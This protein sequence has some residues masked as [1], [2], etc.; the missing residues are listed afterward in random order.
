MS[1][2]MPK[3]KDTKE[4]NASSL[5]LG[6]KDSKAGP[7][8][9]EV[10]TTEE[11]YINS[12]GLLSD[13]K[14]ALALKKYKQKG[15]KDKQKQASFERLLV[16]CKQ[17]NMAHK[18]LFQKLLSPEPLQW[19]EEMKKMQQLY[20]EYNMMFEEINK[21]VPDIVNT[22]IQKEPPPT[23]FPLMSYLIMPV[24]R[25]PR[26][27][28]LLEQM[29]KHMPEK[30]PKRGQMQQAFQQVKDLVS[31]I[32]NA[33]RYATIINDMQV[34]A[35][36]LK[37]SKNKIGGQILD[38]IVFQ[39]KEQ[40][41]RN[42]SVDVALAVGS[43][44][45]EALRTGTREQFKAE[46][47]KIK[48]PHMKNLKAAAE[49]IAVQERQEQEGDE[50]ERKA[51]AH[52]AQTRESRSSLS[53]SSSPPSSLSPPSPPES[54]TESP[55]E[56]EFSPDSP[57]S[58][59][60]VTQPSSHD[61]PLPPL[62]VTPQRK[63]RGSSL[64]PLPS[65]P[66][67][68]KMDPSLLGPLPE[69]PKHARKRVSTFGIDF[70]PLPPLP[71]ERQSRDKKEF[72]A[73]LKSEP[74]N[75]EATAVKLLHLSEETVELEN[76]LLAI[77]RLYQS[78]D[79]PET[80]DELIDRIDNAI[81]ERLKPIDKGQPTEMEKMRIQALQKKK[82]WLQKSGRNPED[83]LVERENEYKRLQQMF[84]QLAQSAPKLPKSRPS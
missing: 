12:L 5:A 46:L 75:L 82:A 80:R 77:N 32:N 51:H 8:Y 14:L 38:K 21:D 19:V 35:D 10:L 74:D 60:S 84:K 48:L 16:L 49:A 31:E 66:K 59:P 72:D 24:Q 39:L 27:V 71:S 3:I 4:F 47:A 26:Y 41:K 6:I 61:L 67:H 25:M 40:Q 58:R 69:L 68:P 79:Y 55:E 42:E 56:S 1:K 34:F 13:K 2:D 50:K 7:V 43:A 70:G 52:Q 83:I 64:P 17:I 28:L 44:Y 22:S 30:A 20:G 36:A 23:P 81:D 62:P 65:A 33:P 37:K 9:L 18:T 57:S 73:S 63:T 53:E 54:I 45:K 78:Q 15:P 11:T 76:W 29:N